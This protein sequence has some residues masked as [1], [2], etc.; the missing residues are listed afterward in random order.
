LRPPDQR[1]W[2]QYIISA[3]PLG[4]Q[5]TGLGGPESA[6]CLLCAR[7]TYSSYFQNVNTDS[8]TFKAWLQNNIVSKNTY[9]DY[10]TQQ[11]NDMAGLPSNT[12]LEAIDRS[13][14]TPKEGTAVLLVTTDR[15][16]SFVHA[17][18]YSKLS[19]DKTLDLFPPIRGYNKAIRCALVLGDM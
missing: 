7:I 13:K 12:I 15:G 8:T 4:Q 6:I 11:K 2:F 14:I 19:V 5:T 18:D 10:L 17:T 16:H 3:G 1:N 9:Y